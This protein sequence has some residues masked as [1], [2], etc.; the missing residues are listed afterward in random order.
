MAVHNLFAD[1][2]AEAGSVLFPVGG[3]RFKEMLPDVVGDAGTIVAEGKNYLSG[4]FLHTDNKIGGVTHVRIV[5][6][7]FPGIGGKIDDNPFEL[8]RIKVNGAVI[9]RDIA[10]SDPVFTEIT[11]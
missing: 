3:E 9:I 2:K 6:K 4:L 1:G 7:T 8:I 10:E 5:L 11:L